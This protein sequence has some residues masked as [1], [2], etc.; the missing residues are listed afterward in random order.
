MI[1]YRSADGPGSTPGQ[2]NLVPRPVGTAALASGAIS[3]PRSQVQV[4]GILGDS[5]PPRFRV[6]P[7]RGSPT[8][9]S[10]YT[11]SASEKDAR[12][13][14]AVEG[15][16]RLGQPSC[17]KG[18]DANSEPALL[19]VSLPVE[20]GRTTNVTDSTASE[21]PDYHKTLNPRGTVRKRSSSEL[22]ETNEPQGL[23]KKT[24][25]ATTSPGPRTMTPTAPSEQET[26]GSKG[27]NDTSYGALI[28]NLHGVQD[29]SAYPQKRL[30]QDRVS[31]KGGGSDSGTGRANHGGGGV[32]T[33]Y[34]KEKKLEGQRE[35]VGSAPVVDLTTGMVLVHSRSDVY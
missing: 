23:N 33:E 13:D 10:F 15:P 16:S 9:P 4:N 29:R 28:E 17:P 3:S 11:S 21:R 32:I 6:R 7:G 19:T 27:S 5:S 14:F 20:K 24:A 31:N 30:K 34:L 22:E 2:Q 26:Y 8:P 12:Y 35:G 25:Q 1:E 18:S